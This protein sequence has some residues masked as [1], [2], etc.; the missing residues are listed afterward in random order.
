MSMVIS[1]EAF[2]CVHV[3]LILYLFIFNGG[4]SMMEKWMVSTEG[5]SF[6]RAE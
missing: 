2:C 5:S 6:N 3:E 1:E 4:D